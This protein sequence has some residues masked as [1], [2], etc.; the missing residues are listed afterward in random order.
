MNEVTQPAD[1]NTM[2]DAQVRQELESN[3]IYPHHKT[4]TEKLR[5]TLKEVRE[6]KYIAP[7][8]G[9]ANAGRVGPSKQ[10]KKQLLIVNS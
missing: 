6:G 10:P 8:A 3:K 5:S 4:G 1:I 2:T 9:A 7:P